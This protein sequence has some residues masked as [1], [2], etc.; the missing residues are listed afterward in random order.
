MNSK[1]ISG[2][3][4][5]LMCVSIV[6]TGCSQGKLSRSKA[7]KLIKEQIQFP[8]YAFGEISKQSQY[9]SVNESEAI[10]DYILRLNRFKEAGLLT[11]ETTKSFYNDDPNDRELTNI[12]VIPTQNGKIYVLKDDDKSYSI[13][14]AD[15]EFK[16]ISGI[17]PNED[18]GAVKAMTV[19][20]QVVWKNMTPFCQNCPSCPKEGT[21]HDERA[22]FVLYDDGWR[23]DKA[24]LLSNLGS[25]ILGLTIY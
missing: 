10:N 23:L 9:W 3:V 14:L 11:Y 17:L 15:I 20:Y 16:Q 19:D 2:L 13:A 24:Q 7:E 18:Y 12:K 22:I 21:V 4:L 8:V 6:I 25:I 5:L 1:I